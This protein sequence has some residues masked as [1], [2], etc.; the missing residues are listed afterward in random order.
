M[1]DALRPAECVKTFV[2]N[3]IGGV[4]AV[5][6]VL[7]VDRLPKLAKRYSPFSVTFGLILSSAPKPNTEPDRV[8]LYPPL[9]PRGRERIGEYCGVVDR[10]RRDAARYVGK[11]VSVGDAE[12]GASR[13]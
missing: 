2:G 11:V 10:S 5:R 3:A 7:V 9:F 1:S 4:K 12:P 6:F 8:A 13:K